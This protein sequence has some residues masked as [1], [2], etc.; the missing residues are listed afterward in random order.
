MRNR[1]K[2]IITLSI[3]VLA[4]SACGIPHLVPR[5]TP[6][7]EDTDMIPPDKTSMPE[8]KTPVSEGQNLDT[9]TKI[10]IQGGG[11]IF[12]IQGDSHSIQIEG[13]R[14]IVEDITYEVK[15]GVLVV[16]YS[17]NI[18]GWMSAFDYPTITINFKQ[19][20]QFVFEGGSEVVAN[21]IQSENLKIEIRGGAKLEMKNLMAD[22]LDLHVEGGANINIDGVVETQALR[23]AGG[24]N[25]EAENLQS[26]TVNLRTEGAV[27]VTIWAADALNLDLSGVYNV[28]YYGNPAITQNVQGAG[29]IEGLGDK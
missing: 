13:P 26:T 9:F 14:N 24:T 23:F 4:A 10:D 16:R 15:D 6:V 28:Q 19:L 12:L 7:P 18:W 20:D 21:D 29:N 22:L 5:T 25:Y 2:I 11:P 8:D 3:L 17:R 1:I 27:S